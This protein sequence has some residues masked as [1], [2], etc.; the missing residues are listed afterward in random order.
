MVK[1]CDLDYDEL[2]RQFNKPLHEAANDL[3]VC[4]TFI[5]KACRTHGIKRCL[6]T[7]ARENR[8]H[9][10]RP[11]RWPYRKVA[12]QSNRALRALIKEEKAKKVMLDYIEENIIK[13]K[14]AIHEC[15]L[16]AASRLQ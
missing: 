10:P 8:A 3:G 1:R 14:E 5:K 7:P 9:R 11:R 2:V 6:L 13:N 4:I 12:A 15:S 16:D